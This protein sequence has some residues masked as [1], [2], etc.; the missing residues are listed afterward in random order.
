LPQQDVSLQ[1][2]TFPLDLPHKFPL[3]LRGQFA[4]HQD[5]LPFGLVTQ[6]ELAVLGEVPLQ[7]AATGLQDAGNGQFGGLDAADQLHDALLEGLSLCRLPP[8]RPFLLHRNA[9]TA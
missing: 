6:S 1:P 3:L 7:H 2:L 5:L 4:D 9:E 8:P